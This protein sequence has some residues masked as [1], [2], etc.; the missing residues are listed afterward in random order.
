MSDD[1]SDTDNIFEYIDGD[2]SEYSTSGD[3]WLPSDEEKRRRKKRRKHTENET[4]SDSSETDDSTTSEE[5]IQT[6][7]RK[8]RKKNKTQRATLGQR[9]IENTDREDELLIIVQPK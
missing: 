5:E 6:P 9:S 7:I 2:R 4:E 8:K 3:E 1:E